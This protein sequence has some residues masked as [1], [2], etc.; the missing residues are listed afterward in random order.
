MSIQ[1]RSTTAPTLW[2][3]DEWSVLR[4]L[5]TRYRQVGDLLTEREL[6]HLRFWRWLY[7]TGRIVP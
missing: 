2:S 6:A 5:R 3:V 4:A 7:R 1:T